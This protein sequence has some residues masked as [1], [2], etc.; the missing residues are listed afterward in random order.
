MTYGGDGD[1]DDDDDRVAEK[2]FNNICNTKVLGCV[3][4]PVYL[5]FLSCT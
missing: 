4:L 3:G 2:H 5:L 1:D